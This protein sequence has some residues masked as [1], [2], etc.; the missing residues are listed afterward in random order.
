[1]DAS[2]PSLPPIVLSDDKLRPKARTTDDVAAH[3]CHFVEC[4]LYVGLVNI[5]MIS[6]A[7]NSFVRATYFV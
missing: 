4:S 5:E 3:G 6:S 1:M 2:C 7:R